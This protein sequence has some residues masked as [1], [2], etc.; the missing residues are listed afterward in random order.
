MER[1]TPRVHARAATA[2][3]Q[4]RSLLLKAENELGLAVSIFEELEDPGSPSVEELRLLMR[5]IE[6]ARLALVA[7]RPGRGENQDRG[8][9][10]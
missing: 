9:V 8:A 3:V 6:H 5:Q 10:A 2:L 1:E 7:A 4:A